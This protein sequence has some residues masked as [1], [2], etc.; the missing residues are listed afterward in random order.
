[1][2][3]IG[4]TPKSSSAADNSGVVTSTG[5]TAEKYQEHT[6]LNGFNR[7]LDANIYKKL[8]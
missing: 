8:N 5:D 1:M 6:A 3:K 2:R 4:P 7:E